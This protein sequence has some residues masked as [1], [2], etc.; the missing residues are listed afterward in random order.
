MINPWKIGDLSLCLTLLLAFAISTPAHSAAERVDVTSETSGRTSSSLAIAPWDGIAAAV[1]TQEWS[2][3]S[4][5]WSRYLTLMQGRARYFATEMPPPMVLAMF[6]R[7]DA[8]R[9]HFTELLARF[10][11][12]KADRLLAVQ[13]SYDAAMARLY[14]AEKIID[15]D[16]LRRQGLLPASTVPGMSNKASDVHL[17]RF[18]DRLALFAASGCDDCGR[19]VRELVSKYSV[20]P[21]EIYFKGESDDL[22]VWL[23]KVALEPAWLKTNGVTFA[24][25]EG[26][27]EQ[28]QAAPGTAF[29]VRGEALYEMS[30]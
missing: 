4:D 11:R 18:G 29:I 27:S 1:A 6:A 21:L 12:D 24:K 15:L 9:D 19:R 30:L 2:L 13:R 17:P 8:E 26:Q 16:I 23:K 20:A 7:N 10:E 5:E 3:S 25:D 28:Y 22:K 14:P